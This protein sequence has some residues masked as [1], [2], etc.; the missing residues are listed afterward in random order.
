VPD[1][2]ALADVS[3][4]IGRGE[5]IGIVGP[6]GAGKST[7]MQLLL[8]LRVPS[9]GRYLVNAR[10]ASEFRTSMWYRTVA[11]L[12]QE[13]RLIDGTIAENI[14]FLRDDVDDE[15]IYRAARLAQIHDE[16]LA[17][18]RGYET[19]VGPRGHAVSGGQRQRICLARALATR[20]SVLVLDEPTSALDVHSELLIQRALDATRG[21]TTLLIVAHRLSTLNICDRIIVLEGGRLEAFAAAKDLMRIS[22]YFTQAVE[23]S[24]LP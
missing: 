13:P 18:P 8:R 3:F 17:W 15:A 23:L 24:R 10:P 9:S 21:E 1:Q 22:A 19:P 6:S 4:S 7:L 12:P 16:I 20:P 11:F 2:P 5:A 14:R